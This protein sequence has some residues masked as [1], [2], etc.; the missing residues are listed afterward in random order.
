M[1]PSSDFDV[2]VFIA[3]E[4][5]FKQERILTKSFY[6]LRA[7]L[8]AVARWAFIVIERFFLGETA[9]SFVHEWQLSLPLRKNSRS[10]SS[11][12]T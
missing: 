4:S 7:R 2:S 6:N 8:I 1:N 10:G 12:Q 11:F 9:T 3:I 5:L